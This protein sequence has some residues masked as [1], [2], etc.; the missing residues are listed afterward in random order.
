MLSRDLYKNELEAHWPTPEKM[1]D[2]DMWMRLPEIRKGRECVVPDISRTYHFGSSGLNM[3]SYFQDVYFKKHA[4]NRQPNIILH[5]VSSLTAANYERTVNDLL[6]RAIVLDHS[7]S[8]CEPNFMPTHPPM[9]H[10][11]SR[12]KNSAEALSSSLSSSVGVG[13]GGNIYVMYIKMSSPRDFTTWLQIAKCFHIWD[14]DPRGYHKGVWRLFLNGNHLLVV[15]VPHS[16]YAKYKPNQVTPI[17][18]D[19]QHRIDENRL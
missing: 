10:G 5:H 3:N 4:F 8:P 18:L 19:D 16:P 15:G 2:W 12:G 13:G 9:L 17:Y 14:L 1:W 6:R 11:D 7:K